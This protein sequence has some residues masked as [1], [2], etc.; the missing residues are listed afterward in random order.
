M[1][2]LTGSSWSCCFCMFQ[3]WTCSP[4]AK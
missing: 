4:G 2:L 1:N 3:D